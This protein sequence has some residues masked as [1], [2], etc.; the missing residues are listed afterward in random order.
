MEKCERRFCVEEECEYK[1]KR[2]KEPKNVLKVTRCAY[3]HLS[4]PVEISV[5]YLLHYIFLT[6]HEIMLFMDKVSDELSQSTDTSHISHL[7]VKIWSSSTLFFFIWFW[8]IFKSLFLIV[9]FKSPKNKPRNSLLHNPTLCIFSC[10]LDKGE[11][12]AFYASRFFNISPKHFF[13][14]IRRL[15]WESAS[16]THIIDLEF[17]ICDPFNFVAAVASSSPLSC[18]SSYLLFQKNQELFCYCVVTVC[19]Q[20]SQRW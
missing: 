18:V 8:M 16:L 9:S 11:S 4:L 13:V 6:F 19:I 5:F 17:F 14:F 10:A 15:T 3:D 12:R 2:A 7:I 1:K 20:A